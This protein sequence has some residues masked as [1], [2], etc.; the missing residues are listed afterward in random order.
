M[1]VIQ[2]ENPTL[3]LLSKPLEERIY[4]TTVLSVFCGCEAQSLTLREE[5]GLQLFESKVL[6]K[7][8]GTK[9]NEENEQV[10]ILHNKE[11]HYLHRSPSTIKTV[12]L[13]RLCR[14]GSVI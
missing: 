11:L 8:F 5:L 7:I 6:M 10:R 14:A 2:V 13:R 12:R 9:K 4:K 3:C 1:L